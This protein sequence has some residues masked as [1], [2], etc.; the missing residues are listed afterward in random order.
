MGC[1][2]AVPRSI[3]RSG[4]TVGT[5]VAISLIAFWGTGKAPAQSGTPLSESEALYARVVRT[6]HNSDHVRNGR[7]LI[8]V[9]APRSGE[10]EEDLYAGDAE[11]GFH[12]AG[13]IKDVSFQEGLCCGT[14]YEL[15]QKVGALK[16][17]TLLWAG[18]IGGK[19]KAN[20]MHIGIYSSTDGAAS[21]HYLSDCA[22]ARGARASV[23]GLWEPE[24][25]VASDGALVCFYSDETQ[26]H[27]SQLLNQVR[28][29]DGVHWSAPE[30]TVAL[31][32]PAARPGMPVVTR[33]KPDLYFMTYEIC[34]TVH[35][36][37]FSRT[38]PDGWNWGDAADAGRKIVGE[39]GQYFEHAPTNTKVVL[40]NGRT[41]LI[42]VGQMLIEAD[43]S[44]SKQNGQVLFLNDTADGSGSWRTMKAPIAVPDAYDNYCPNYS[45]PLLPGR[46]GRTILE[47][48]S[49]YANGV[50]RMYYGTGAISVK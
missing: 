1:Q 18:S 40:P 2:P 13:S 19:S 46:N 20:P 10:F 8:S 5:L 35:C 36:A 12:L 17:G 9:T 3:V 23:G 48:A 45:S 31:A 6:A 28:S 29:Y 49:R 16:S 47:V 21:W 39:N 4:V 27:H 38:S 26:P 15:P 37:A 22:V 43:G 44:V 30:H 25:T 7:I 41:E 42:A 34:G 32:D 11:T 50:C 33:L 24:F 14:L